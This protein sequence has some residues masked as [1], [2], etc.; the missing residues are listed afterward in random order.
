MFAMFSSASMSA[1]DVKI[2][3]VK[4]LKE[5]EASNEVNVKEMKSLISELLPT[6]YILKGKVSNYGTTSPI[7]LET[8]IQ[9]IKDISILS[10]KLGNV[11]I[12]KISLNSTSDLN[13]KINTDDFKSLGLLKYVYVVA[14]FEAKESQIAN[15]IVNNN[16]E[17]IILFSASGK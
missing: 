5:G 16:P 6:V 14:N 15:M 1:Q 4:T 2:L 8:D 12:A 13:A 10:S 11:K 9:G 3:E 17:I 7:K